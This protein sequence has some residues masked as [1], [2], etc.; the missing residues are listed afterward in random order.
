MPYKAIPAPHL[1]DKYDP[2]FVVIDAETGEILDDAQG[3]GYKSL[4]KAYAG[5]AY[6]TR[7]KSKDVAKREIWQRVRKW[8]CEHQS[9]VEQLQDISFRIEKGSCGP[10][11]KLD[12]KTLAALFKDAGHTDL[13]FTPGEFLRYWNKDRF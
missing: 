3:Y 13:P 12:A 11:V 9:F 6:K 10:D 1:S 4:Q 2:R 5:Y 8:C 7:D